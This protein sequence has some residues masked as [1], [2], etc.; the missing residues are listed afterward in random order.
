MSLL[1]R[2]DNYT[3][4]RWLYRY[5]IHLRTNSLDV[6]VTS[7]WL[8]L[9]L[10]VFMLTFNR[11]EKDHIGLGS[12]CNRATTIAEYIKGTYKRVQQAL[13]VIYAI[14]GLTGRW[15]NGFRRV[16]EKLEQLAS[17]R[18]FDIKF[19]QNRQKTLF[20]RSHGDIEITL[21][22]MLKVLRKQR[23]DLKGVFNCAFVKQTI[24]QLHNSLWVV[25]HNCLCL[26]SLVP[27]RWC[28]W[29]KKVH[30]YSFWKLL[31]GHHTLLRHSP[32]PL[33]LR[34]IYTLLPSSKI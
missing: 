31:T 13:P 2:R 28:C 8:F 6:S 14:P 7:N 22:P 15:R 33:N 11:D 30:R 21:Q 12:N 4:Y 9:S 20:M 34:S 17:F 5:I 23:T 25:H 16:D 19:W 3:L 1:T 26:F 29:H 18:Q 24:N 10:H 27:P 32:Y